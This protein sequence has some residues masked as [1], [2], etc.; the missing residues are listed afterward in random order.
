[1]DA[2]KQYDAAAAKAMA[3][4]CDKRIER[5]RR[6]LTKIAEHAKA[7]QNGSAAYALDRL[8]Q[9]EKVANLAIARV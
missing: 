3:V 1:M 2:A 8:R 7:G 9:I 5:A 6:H 4:H